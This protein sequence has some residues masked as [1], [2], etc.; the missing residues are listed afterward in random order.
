MDGQKQ[1]QC[2]FMRVVPI[3]ARYLRIPGHRRLALS[4]RFLTLDRFGSWRRQGRRAVIRWAR[5]RPWVRGCRGAEGKAQGQV[6]AT[7]RENN[8]GELAHKRSC[9]E[10][11]G[12][13]GCRTNGEGG[14]GGEGAHPWHGPMSYPMSGLMVELGAFPL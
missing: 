12:A 4:V 3:T 10:E 1:A 11:E 13:D 2:E 9:G 8:I 5:D 7:G 14:R 6:G